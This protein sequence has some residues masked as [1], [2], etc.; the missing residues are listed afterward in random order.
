MDTILLTP[1]TLKELQINLNDAIENTAF[2]SGGTD[3]IL[4]LREHGFRDRSLIDL[5]GINELKFIIETDNEITIGALTTLSEISE[6]ELI[7]KHAPMLAKA[8]DCVGST[9]IRNVATIGGNIANAFAGADLIPPLFALD[10]KIDIIGKNHNKRTVL[11]N[12]FLLGNR[13]NCLKFDE[14]VKQVRFEVQPSMQYFGKIGARKRVTISK[15]NIAVKITLREKTIESVRIA[16]GALGQKAFLSEIAEKLLINKDIDTI[17]LEDLKSVFIEQVDLAIPSRQSR[18]YK[19]DA[20]ISL[21]E[22][23]YQI[24]QIEKEV[25]YE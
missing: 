9:Q 5:S 4:N 1:N 3:M 6:H 23:L 12:D 18:I 17:E 13:K 7:K 14:M 19:R 24:I 21:A 20:V 8:A 22:E 2:I 11:I 10:A 25:Y 16:F 15:L